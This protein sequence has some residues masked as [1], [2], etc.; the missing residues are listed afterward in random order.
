M[1]YL[2][3]GLHDTSIFTSLP[4]VSSRV[5]LDAVVEETYQE[6]M[7]L[8]EYYDQMNEEIAKQEREEAEKAREAE[9]LPAVVDAVLAEDEEVRNDVMFLVQ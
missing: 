5:D 4:P 1:F 2:R 9:G 6:A 8:Y 7:R 3:C